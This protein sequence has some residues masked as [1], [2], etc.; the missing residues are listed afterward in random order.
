MGLIG[1]LGKHV[2][3]LVRADWKKTAKILELLKTYSESERNLLTFQTATG[4][5]S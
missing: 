4:S 5:L 1:K 3:A 2:P